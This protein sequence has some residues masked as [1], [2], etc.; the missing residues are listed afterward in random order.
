MSA[1]RLLRF[2]LAFMVICLALPALPA[3][4]EVELS[5]YGGAQSTR[6]STIRSA[7][8]GD[9]RVSWEARPF[10]VPKYYGLRAQW[11]SDRHLGF[12]VDFSHSKAYADDPTKYGYETLNF[13]HGL[14][15]LTANIWYRF[16]SRGK[17]TPYVG[18]G[19]GVAIPHVEV[20]PIGLGSTATYQ[21]AGPAVTVVVGASM[22][23]AGRWSLFTE[24]K[25]SFSRL[26]TKLDTGDRLDTD[27]F[28]DALNVGVSLRF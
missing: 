6:P 3:R 20:Q 23:I 17:I 5:F 9:D 13:S 1:G 27:I 10:E 11:W 24:Y 28:T 22:P 21:V 25:G 16:D 18:A 8:L 14:N 2:L 15:V 19:L 26:K 4:S 12:G 7:T